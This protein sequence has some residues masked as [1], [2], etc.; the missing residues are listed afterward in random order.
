M[1]GLNDVGVEINIIICNRHFYDGE[2]KKVLFPVISL[3]KTFA[4]PKKRI[5]D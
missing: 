5:A 3:G 1:A 4:S 2:A